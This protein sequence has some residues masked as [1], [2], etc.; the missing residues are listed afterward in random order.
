M[1]LT[2][3]EEL[4]LAVVENLTE[5]ETA[6]YLITND[7]DTAPKWF[8]DHL[9]ENEGYPTFIVDIFDVPNT[10]GVISSAVKS[11]KETISTKPLAE[12]SQLPMLVV[13]SKNFLRVVTYNGSI[14]AELGL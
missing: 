11:V 2:T 7:W 3:S 5:R 13:I 12:Y 4:E 10:L 6:Y 1:N 14:G 9:K 8:K